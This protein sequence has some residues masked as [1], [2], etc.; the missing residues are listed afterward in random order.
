MTPKLFER[1]RK[2]AGLTQIQ[3]A[4]DLGYTV[5]QIYRFE[6]GITKIRPGLAAYMLS[7]T[8]AEKS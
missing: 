2:K 7:L 5:R 1:L 3:L 8:A 4:E 6:H